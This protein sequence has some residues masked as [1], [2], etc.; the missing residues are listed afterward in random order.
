MTTA[1]ATIDGEII[2]EHT[3]APVTLFGTTDPAAVVERASALATA[4]A[5]V[6]EQ[7]RLYKRIGNKN[8]VFV[9][10]WTLLGS[11]LGVFAEVEWTRPTSSGWEA[12]AVART[13]GGNL[14]GAAEAM[15][16][17]DESKWKNADDYAVRSMAQTRAVSKALRLPLG[18][19]VELAGYSATPA[20]ELDQQPAESQEE[21]PARQVIPREELQARLLKAAADRGIVQG[22]VKAMAE[23]VYGK[24]FAELREELVPFGKDIVAG[25]YDLPFEQPQES[26]SGPL[27]D[28]AGS[29]T[30]ATPPAAIEQPETVPTSPV[31][32]EPG[33][34]P[35]SGSGT[36]TAQQGSA[37]PTSDGAGSSGHEEGQPAPSGDLM[38][39]VLDITQ[40][41]EVIEPPKPGTDQ[42]KALSGYEKSQ[43]RAYWSKAEPKGAR[44]THE[45]AEVP[46]GAK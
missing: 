2:E 23:Q 12:R 46:A 16:S 10:G 38:Q 20:E 44:P 43:A 33:F 42:F 26:T 15:C 24:P 39:Q 34:S 6:I 27:P 3:T 40:G 21:H 28:D 8:H 37:A 36:H 41:T 18:Y 32:P 29:Q 31:D 9:E 1:L 4:L 19:I 11:M 45:P 30:G 14:V 22:H 7:K 5:G 25:K 13:L 35:R 17:R